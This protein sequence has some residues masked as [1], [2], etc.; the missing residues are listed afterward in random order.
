MVEKNK[1][2]S[3]LSIYKHIHYEQI[4][5]FINKNPYKVINLLITKNIIAYNKESNTVSLIGEKS[6]INF[7][8]IK[9]LWVLADFKNSLIEH[10]LTDTEE[11]YA[12][13]KKGELEIFN[14]A[15]GY[16]NLAN[17]SHKESECKKI[18]VLDDIEQSKKIDLS[19]IIYFVVFDGDNR[20]YYKKE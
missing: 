3:L 18:I 15:T 17:H 4:G 12:I 5:K 11:I 19:N 16:E 1:I 6:M 2:V 9:L 20:K 14:V 7:E 8:T 10:L 13:T